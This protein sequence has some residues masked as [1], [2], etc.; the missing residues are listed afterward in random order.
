[1]T[2]WLRIGSP[3]VALLVSFWVPAYSI[4]RA[5]VCA[6]S[7]KHC[8][9]LPLLERSSSIITA[10]LG[11]VPKS[12]LNHLFNAHVYALPVAL[13]INAVLWALAAAAITMALT[14]R[15]SGRA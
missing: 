1:M 5:I 8:T 9:S 14:T 7:S 6:E 4:G 13:G 12:S 2:R 10:P 3:V 11:L 15:P